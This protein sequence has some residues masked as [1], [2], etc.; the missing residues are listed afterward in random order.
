MSDIRQGSL[1][2]GIG[3]MAGV[4]FAPLCTLFAACSC[5]DFFKG[6]GSVWIECLICTIALAIFF[7]ILGMAF[8]L[9][10]RPIHRRFLDRP[11]LRDSITCIV[12]TSVIF[13]LLVFL[14]GMPSG[15]HGPDI[16]NRWIL[17]SLI[18]GV[19]F[20]AIFARV[21]EADRRRS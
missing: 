18:C 15:T 9:F 2:I 8:T 21:S 11:V 7:G 14:E 17:F 5:G 6:G 1:T 13:N 19:Y 10:A 4:F 20:A 12:L 3:R 16:P